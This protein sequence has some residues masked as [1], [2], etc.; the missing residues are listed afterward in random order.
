MTSV[1]VN[2]IEIILKILS[3]MDS[4]TGHSNLNHVES[5]TEHHQRVVS[6]YSQIL[7]LRSGVVIW[8][9]CRE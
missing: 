3:S 4:C 7:L 8:G 1:E 2:Q 6:L 9:P 5:D